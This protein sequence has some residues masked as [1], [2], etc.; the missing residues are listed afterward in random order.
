MINL[1]VDMNENEKVAILLLS[2]SS[3]YLIVGF[4]SNAFETITTFNEILFEIEM[5]LN[6]SLI[7]SSIIAYLF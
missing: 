6:K 4:K 7:F 5:K 1:I 2:V 3:D